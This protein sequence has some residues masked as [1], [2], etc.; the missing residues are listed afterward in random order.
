[1]RYSNKFSLFQEGILIPDVVWNRTLETLDGTVNCIIK[2]LRTVANYAD[3]CAYTTWVNWNSLLPCM[4]IF[5]QI[6]SSAISHFQ[7]KC[8]NF[9]N[10]TETDSNDRSRR[11][12]THTVWIVSGAVTRSFH[13]FLSRK[14]PVYRRLLLFLI[15]RKINLSLISIDRRERKASRFWKMSLT[16]KL[17]DL[18]CWLIFVY[19]VLDVLSAILTYTNPTSQIGS[20]TSLKT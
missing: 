7:V 5:K 12:R 18:L 9:L 11:L 19:Y 10:F 14:F 15:T 6:C 4:E 16:A 2:T 17:R 1:M 20:N 3:I 8:C 13:R